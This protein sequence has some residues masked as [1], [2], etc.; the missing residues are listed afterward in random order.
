MNKAVINKE[1]SQLLTRKNISQKEIAVDTKTPNSSMNGYVSR[2][3]SVPVAK[4]G[5]IA[6]MNGDDI[7]KSQMAYI[8]F[9]FIKAMDGKLIDVCTV[10]E[11]DLL[12][13]VENQERLSRKERAH[14]LVIQSKVREL[15][16]HEKDEIKT[17]IYE[18]LDEIVVELSIVM[19]LLQ[20]VGMS[21]NE[22]FKMRL[23]KWQNDNYMGE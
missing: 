2:S 23:P 8:Y 22:A 15:E 5:D 21:I 10:A 19:S 1:L 6:E 13:A 11:L 7:Y 17:Y 3:H 20:I 9:G 14:L 18:F 12:E 4:A 16:H